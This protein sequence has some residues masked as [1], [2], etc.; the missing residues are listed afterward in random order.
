ML[1]GFSVNALVKGVPIQASTTIIGKIKNFFF[2][3]LQFLKKICTVR[4]LWLN[5]HPN[6]GGNSTFFNFR[7]DGRVVDYT[8]LENRRAERH[9]GFESLSLR[10]EVE[11]G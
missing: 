2:K 3:N 1:S 4:F 11:T 8:G 10:Q 6:F 9:R 7:R 5:L